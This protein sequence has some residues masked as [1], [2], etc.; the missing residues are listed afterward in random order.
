MVKIRFP[1]V[2]AA[3]LIVIAISAGQATAGNPDCGVS[4]APQLRQ[5]P[6][7]AVLPIRDTQSTG[8]GGPNSCWGACFSNYSECMDMRPKAHCVATMKLCLETCDR[9]SSR[10]GS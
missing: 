5:C 2:P 9:L 10:P 1:I 6:A 3:V 8:R 4:R 7:L